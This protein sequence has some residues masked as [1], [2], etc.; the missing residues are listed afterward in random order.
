MPHT[1]RGTFS[2]RQP[3]RLLLQS[4][5]ENYLESVGPRLMVSGLI[6]LKVFC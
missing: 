6:V 2:F 5:M 3:E 1:D 4:F